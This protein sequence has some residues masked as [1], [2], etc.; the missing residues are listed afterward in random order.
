[1]SNQELPSGLMARGSRISL[2]IC[3]GLIVLVVAIYAQTLRHD[4][5]NYDDNEYVTENPMVLQGLTIFLRH[6][7]NLA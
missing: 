4:F 6:H 5:L 7:L 2:L 1:M 3:L